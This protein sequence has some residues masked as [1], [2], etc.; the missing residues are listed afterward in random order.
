MMNTYTDSTNMNIPNNKHNEKFDINKIKITNKN[1]EK[2]GY[3]LISKINDYIYLGSYEHP[4]SNSRFFK[5]LKIDVIINCAKEI[6]YNSDIPVKHFEIIDGDDISML[7]NMDIIVDTIN[8]YIS[9]GKKIYLHCAQGISRS[10]AI[11]IYYLMLYSDYTYYEAID[12]VKLKRSM[13]DI[14]M[15]FDN[16][17]RIIEDI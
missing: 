17:L 12:F 16:Q 1:F 10:P 6:S 2:Y 13:I 7:D 4:A 3:L 8:K 9:E 14:D 15:V 11:L 5:E